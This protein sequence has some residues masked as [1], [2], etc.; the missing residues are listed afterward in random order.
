MLNLSISHIIN[1]SYKQQ[2]FMAANIPITWRNHDLLLKSHNV[3][4]LGCFQDPRGF[5]VGFL[6]SVHLRPSWAVWRVAAYPPLKGMYPHPTPQVRTPLSRWRWVRIL[7]SSECPNS[8]WECRIS[9]NLKNTCI[10]FSY[11][12]KNKKCLL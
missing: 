10:I 7:K 2:V 5:Y 8:S 4:P 9:F 6:N 11:F 12:C 3:G 1:Y